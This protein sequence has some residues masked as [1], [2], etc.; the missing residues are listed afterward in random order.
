MTTAILYGLPRDLGTAQLARAIARHCRVPVSTET[1]WD[2]DR[3]EMRLDLGRTP[4]AT[5][6]CAVE[7][8][9]LVLGVRYAILD[10]GDNPQHY[11]QRNRVVASRTI[12]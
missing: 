9:T 3:V 10:D 6:T 7:L 4:A 8:Y 1:L 11:P 5:A 2:H 12:G